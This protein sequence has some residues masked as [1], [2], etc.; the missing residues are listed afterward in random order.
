MLRAITAL[1]I[2]S[3]N[4]YSN[5]MKQIL[6]YPNFID[7]DLW[8]Q[9]LHNLLKYTQYSEWQSRD[10]NP[11]SLAL[12]SVLLT[13]FPGITGINTHLRRVHFT[14][15]NPSSLS[16]SPESTLLPPPP[17]LC[18]FL[19]RLGMAHVTHFHSK[20]PPE[21]LN[22]YCF[23]RVGGSCNEETRLA[24]ARYS[25][26]LRRFL[27]ALQLRSLWESNRNHRILS[28]EKCTYGF[29]RKSQGGSPPEA[30]SRSPGKLS[31]YTNLKPG[32]YVTTRNTQQRQMRD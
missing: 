29:C 27:T 25:E 10:L 32:L 13:L 1:Y 5:L 8:A 28:P 9:K 31:C 16:C 20:G 12:E 4:P 26:H 15:S 17:S 3:F 22:R 7:E 21:I 30:Y 18:S 6:Y 14:L 24:T 23:H 2:I 19:C 11:A